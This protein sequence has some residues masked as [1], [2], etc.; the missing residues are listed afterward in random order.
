MKGDG[1]GTTR[2]DSRNDLIL[3]HVFGFAIELV[4]NCIDPCDLVIRGRLGSLTEQT[5]NRLSNK[6]RTI[7]R[8]MVDL[9]GQIFRKVHLN[10]H[11]SN[12]KPRLRRESMDTDASRDTR[13]SK[14]MRR[15]GLHSL[16]A[17]RPT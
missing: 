4:G 7:R 13:E 15:C 6:S 3:E 5:P 9:R 2:L 16:D 10:T 14:R 11:A 8:D 12:S 1:R 17:A